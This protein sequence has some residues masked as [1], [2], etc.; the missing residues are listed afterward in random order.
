MKIAIIG[1]GIF[2]ITT[3]F[4]LKSSGYDCV[5]IE[6][7]NK[8]MLGASTNNLNRLHFGYHYPR[9]SETAKK[10]IEGYKTFSKFYKSSIVKS[11]NNYYLIAKHKSL[12]NFKKYLKFCVKNKL[13]FKIIKNNNFFIKTNKIE[14][15]IKVFEPIYSWE[16]LK[17]IIKK[18]IKNKNIKDHIYLNTKVLNVIYKKK[19][20]LIKTNKANFIADIILD[21]S[22]FSL[23]Y[24]FIK[25]KKIKEY[26]KKIINQIT[27]VGEISLKK[28]G[29]LG[30]AVMDGPFFS[31]LPQGNKFEHLIYH[32]KYS[33]IK[34]SQKKNFTNI[35]KKVDYIKYFEKFKYL[36][37]KD[38]KNFFPKLEIKFT[39]KFFI[40]RRVLLNNKTDK[41]VSSITEIKKNYFLILSG[42]VDHSVNIAK[43]FVKIISVKV[44][45]K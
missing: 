33:V 28:L 38:L 2:G 13:L 18:K 21:T 14:G 15:I 4:L 5:L 23:N 43:E 40:S 35:K 24:N 6:K 42:K 37:S 36:V 10:S 20:Y 45:Q 11:F 31:I 8:L 27:I 17:D 41:R 9:D 44:Q 22:Y 19:F 34:E 3:F 12:V 29:R 1:G 16:K 30:L 7:K 26:L 39:N 32:V 25:S